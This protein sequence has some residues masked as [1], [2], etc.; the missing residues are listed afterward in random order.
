MSKRDYYDV[1][2]ISKTADAKDIKAAF[3][4][5]AKT[6]HPDSNQNDKS[7]E[8]KFREIG[9]AYEVLSDEKKRAQYDRFG[10]GAF[11]GGRGGGG[12]GAGA[13]GFEGFGGAS[14]SDIFDEMFGDVMG[15]A[16]RSSGSN[17][18]G[19]DLRYNMEITLEEAFRGHQATITIPTW[20]SCDTCSGSGAEAGSTPITCPTCSGIGRIRTQ[21]GFF[22]VERT[23]HTCQGVGK[24]IKNPCK[25]CSGSGRLRRDRT[26]KVTIPAGVEDGTR[27][28]LAGEGEAGVRG[29]SA[30]DLYVFL[31]ISKHRFFQR[32][33]A[34]LKCR[35]PMP[36]TTA[37]LGG[38]IEVPTIE[39]TRSRITV[40]AGTQTGQQFRLKGK[41]M[42]ILR[43]AQRGDMYVEVAV[44]TPVNL[45]KK[46]EDLL[47][48]FADI[49]DKD[50]KHSPQSHSFF[51]KVKEIWS[52]LT[53]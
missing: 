38:H 9:E 30:G 45:T 27:I 41:G 24:I 23:C 14:F 7:A 21:Q 43:S 46:Q 8:E 47:K 17:T 34:D 22:T 42:S 16:K 3:R 13:A 5:L 15:G 18:R 36:M 53:E 6:Y 20:V 37:A 48:Q 52:D 33:T 2:G 31:S 19:N 28:R 10:H 12:G 29:G 39:G 1:L 4:K 11:E 25:S 32:E 50:G 26:L 49:G 51:S 44:E 35:V 40:P